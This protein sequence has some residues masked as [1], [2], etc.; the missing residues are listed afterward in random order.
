M[1]QYIGG[2]YVPRF[3]GTY[4][5]T[6][7]YEALDV[8]DNG[9]GTSYISKI[10]TPAGTPL[11]DTTHW[12]IY[13]AS[14]GAIINLQNQINALDDRVEAVEDSGSNIMFIM[15]SYGNLVDSSSK[16]VDEIVASRTGAYCERIALA[17]ASFY[18]GT[19]E[20]AVASY[21]GDATKFDTVVL[22][23]G[24][25]DESHVAADASTIATNMDSCINT[26]KSTFTNAKRILVMCP[27][28]TFDSTFTIKILDGLAALY[29]EGSERNGVK[30]IDNSQYI[31]RNT[32][33]LGADNCHPNTSGVRELA[34]QAIQAIKTDHCDVH[35]IL[36][37]TFT[38]IDSTPTTYNYRMTR[39]NAF[40]TL[41]QRDFG[42][43]LAQLND[44]ITVDSNVLI[45]LGEFANT[46]IESYDSVGLNAYNSTGVITDGSSQPDYVRAGV[47]VKDKH[48]M[49]Y[50]GPLWRYSGHTSITGTQLKLIGTFTIHD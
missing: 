4:D 28:L 48:L 1:G 12:A 18:G 7:V 26:I 34:Y 45:D 20:S 36:D 31:F 21:T 15:D 9:S 42:G 32:S 38:T 17:G 33:L 41:T 46:L 35:Y 13:G 24:A 27:G 6:Q 10:P 29:K 19:F 39:D 11:T 16:H 8:V 25:N 14:S 43:T 37:I 49:G 22:I 44:S 40:V 23:G 5:P 3:M 30:Y 50:I 47:V 2:R